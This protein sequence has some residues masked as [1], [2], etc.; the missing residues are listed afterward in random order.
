VGRDLPDTGGY[1]SMHQEGG[2]V[3]GTGGDNSNWSVGY[4]LRP[5]AK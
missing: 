2:I 1:T 3:L 4:G 5:I